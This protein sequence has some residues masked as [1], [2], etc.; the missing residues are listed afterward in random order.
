[1]QKLQQQQMQ[2]VE[3]AGRHKRKA[4]EQ[5]ERTIEI[6][7]CISQMRMRFTEAPR[8]SEAK[9]LDEKSMDFADEEKKRAYQDALKLERAAAKRVAE[10][11]ETT[12]TV[13][14]ERKRPVETDGD[15][16][17]NGG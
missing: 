3:A 16:R 7:K 6:G 5:E 11:G 10:I 4:A 14:M 12:R 2:L 17:A 15:V 1:M 9:V 8:E 13:Q